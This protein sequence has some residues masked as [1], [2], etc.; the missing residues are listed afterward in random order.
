[1]ALIECPECGR[2]V[3]DQAVAC[4]SCA[5]PITAAT[6]N[7]AD[8]QT[9]EKTS[10][11]HKGMQLVG[12]LISSL[13]VVSIVTGVTSTSL[14]DPQGWIGLGFL[15]FVAGFVVLLVGQVGAWWHHG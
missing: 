8:A 12:V 14:G 2:K 4:P 11:H 15:L 3:S 5:F 7:P 6:D 9:I 10:K 1:M 13:G